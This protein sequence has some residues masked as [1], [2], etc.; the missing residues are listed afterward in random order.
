MSE[1]TMRIPG[2][3]GL[4]EGQYTIATRF[5]KRLFVSA[6]AGSGKTFSLT[7]RVIRALEEGSAPDGGR[8]M[9][10]I[11]EALIITFTEKAAK[12]IKERIRAELMRRGHAEQALG[13]DGAWISTIHGMCSRLLR[14]HA[15]TV[16]IDPDFHVLE[17]NVVRELRSFAISNAIRESST[18]S[19]LDQLIRMYP[20]SGHSLSSRD[21]ASTVSGMVERMMVKAAS[22]PGGLDAFEM[23]GYDAPVVLDA[24]GNEVNPPLLDALIPARRLQTLTKRAIGLYTSYKRSR[25]VLDNDDLL[26]LCA[27][28]LDDARIA[29]ETAARFK[30]VMVDEFQDTSSQQVRIINRLI[31][32]RPEKLIT[33]GDAQQSIYRFRGADVGVFT[34]MQDGLAAREAA[35]GPVMLAKIDENFR[36]HTDILRFVRTVCAGGEDGPAPGEEALL[37]RF[38]D[39]IPEQEDSDPAKAE[40]A[41]LRHIRAFGGEEFD[42]RPRVFVEASAGGRSDDRRR[43]IARGIAERFRSLHERNGIAYADMA[44]LI[45]STGSYGI[46]MDAMREQGIACLVTGGSNFSRLSEVRVVAELLRTLANPHDPNGGLFPL[47]SSGMIGLEAED[48]VLLGSGEDARTRALSRRELERFYLDPSATVPEGFQE[49]E[50]IRLAREVLT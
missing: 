22:M 37:P 36:S 2:Y 13:V 3:E 26:N 41:R 34:Q 44:L 20:V 31:A 45:G 8:I 23:I 47:L 1:G 38:M 17:E 9:D 33:V 32:D 43:A 35:G 5:D 49:T 19:Y 40:R 16:G 25:N 12:E 29:Q 46:Y 39:L 6:G 48:L 14:Q 18:S 7:Q 24:K 42:G 50:R 28:L 10:S 30:L 11:D 15:F 27:E 4:N 21:G